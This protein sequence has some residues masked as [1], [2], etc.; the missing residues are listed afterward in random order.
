MT[1]LVH[2]MEASLYTKKYIPLRICPHM[3]QIQLAVDNKSLYL[4]AQVELILI[5]HNHRLMSF[6]KEE[7]SHHQIQS[8]VIIPTTLYGL[9]ASVMPAKQCESSEYILHERT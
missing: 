5:S 1:F 3:G 2:G 9:K 8:R 4:Q 6:V 7:D